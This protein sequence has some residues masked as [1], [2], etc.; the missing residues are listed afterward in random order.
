MCVWMCANSA[1]DTGLMSLVLNEWTQKKLAFQH[2]R[3][4]LI[5]THTHTYTHD[6]SQHQTK[7][8]WESEGLG[9]T[10]SYT[11]G[12]LVVNSETFDRIDG[13][14]FEVWVFWLFFSLC[15]FFLIWGR[16]FYSQSATNL[17]DFGS[18]IHSW[19]SQRNEK[20]HETR[21]FW[22]VGGARAGKINTNENTATNETDKIRVTVW[23]GRTY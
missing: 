16:R 20:L 22:G 10:V 2:Q 6:K 14:N 23:E 21:K 11:R 3:I 19:R 4:E 12:I 5:S 18:P 9:E 7:R 8:G 1:L 15:L 13:Q 17:E